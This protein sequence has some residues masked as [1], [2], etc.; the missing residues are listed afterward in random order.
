MKN[1]AFLAV[2]SASILCQ[3]CACKGIFIDVNEADVKIDAK[4]ELEVDFKKG[5]AK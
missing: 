3:G 5:E 2:L 1:L 4:G